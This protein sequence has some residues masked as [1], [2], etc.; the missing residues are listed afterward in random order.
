MQA[1]PDDPLSALVLLTLDHDARVVV[2]YGQ[3]AWTHTTP[4][5]QAQAGEPAQILVRGLLADTDYQLQARAEPGGWTS[6]PLTLR[7]HPLPADFPT[8]TST[9]YADPAEFDEDEVLCTNGSTEGDDRFYLCVDRWGRPRLRV[10]TTLDDSL[11][12]MRALSTGG[13]ASTAYNNSKV[14]LF[15]AAGA[16]TAQYTAS[17]FE[18]STR[19]LHDHVDSHEL[20]E[21]PGGDWQGALVFLTSTTEYFEDGSYKLGNG[22]IVMDPDTGAVIY[23][24]SLHGESGDGVAMDPA[25]PYTRSGNGDYAQDWTHAN[26]VLWDQDADGREY[27]LV[28]LKAQD[29]IVKLYPD[30]D[31][32]AWRLGFDGDFALVDDLDAAAPAPRS[33]LDWF[34]HQHSPVFVTREGSQRELLLFDNGYPRNDGTAYRDDLYYSRVVQLRY[35]EETM[36][37]ELVATY[38]ELEG[39]E[40]IGPMFA[41]TCGS[42]TLLPGEDRVIGLLGE[43]DTFFE[44]SWPDGELRWEMSCTSSEWC[45]YRATWAPSLYELQW[46]TR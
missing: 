40:S 32:I 23:D 4:A 7:T 5:V 25:V 22:L 14:A 42:V 11:M 29:W 28:S 43:R 31:E 17:W 30:T 46:D 35:D 33:D 24:Y 3:G 12:S 34:Y 13:W 44:R 10:E 38:G 8:C 41:L 19:F 2:D 16:Q 39:G 6:D 26:T 20:Y 45:S 18:G 27:L 37:A 1:N 36:R 21:I 9:F 15:D